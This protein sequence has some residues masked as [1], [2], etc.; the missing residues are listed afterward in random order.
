ML[1]G[2]KIPATGVLADIL[3]GIQQ[4]QLSMNQ[5]ST[6]QQQIWNKLV[7]LE[8]NASQQLTS[9][10]QQVANTKQDFRIFATEKQSFVGDQT[11]KSLEFQGD[12]KDLEQARRFIPQ[13]E[14]EYNE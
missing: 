11:K 14:S 2:Q 1:T 6:Q 10:S 5:V 3:S 13:S 4:V 9:L 8:N 12:R 7:N